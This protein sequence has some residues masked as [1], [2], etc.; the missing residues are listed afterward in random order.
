M[1]VLL[2]KYHNKKMLKMYSNQGGLC[3][4]LTIKDSIIKISTRFNILKIYAQSFI[5]F[6]KC[7]TLICGSFFLHTGSL[8]TS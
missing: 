6:L 8:L 3:F 2:Y 7:V 1:S 5:D 4:T